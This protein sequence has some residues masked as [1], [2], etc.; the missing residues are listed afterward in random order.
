M[1]LLSNKCLC[2]AYGSIIRSCDILEEKLIILFT[3][4]SHF[5]GLE[6]IIRIT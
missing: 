2:D 4:P 6:N 5:W 3:M 1:V